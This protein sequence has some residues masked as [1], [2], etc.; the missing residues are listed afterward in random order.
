MNQDPLGKQG[1]RTS[2]HAPAN[3]IPVPSTSKDAVAIIA[4]CDAALPSQKWTYAN[5]TSGVAD[6]LFV[7]QCNAA[8]KYQV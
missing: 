3:T 4:A 6:L 1:R 2:V 5:A 7:V 8:D